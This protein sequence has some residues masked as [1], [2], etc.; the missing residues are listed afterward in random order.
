[1]N[2]PEKKIERIKHDH[3]RGKKAEIQTDL[4]IKNQSL[5]VDVITGATASSKAILKATENALKK[6][7]R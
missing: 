2:I 4:I 3:G 5:N 6:G 7:I 1:M